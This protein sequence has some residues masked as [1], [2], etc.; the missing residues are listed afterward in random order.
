LVA[1]GAKEISRRRASFQSV[2][3]VNRTCLMGALRQ[4]SFA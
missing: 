1:I 4:T 2:P 3:S